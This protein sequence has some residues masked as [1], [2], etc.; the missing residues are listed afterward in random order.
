MK[1]FITWICLLLL[2][3]VGKGLEWYEEGNPVFLTEANMEP[4]LLDKSSIKVVKFFAPF[5]GYCRYLKNFVD[6]F[7][8]NN[9]I[10]PNLKFYEMNCQETRLCSS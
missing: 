9:Q 7:K 6:E 10:H 2:S 5:C 8:R 4:A 3:E 1:L